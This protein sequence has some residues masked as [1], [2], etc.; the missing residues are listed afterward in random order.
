MGNETQVRTPTIV[1]VHRVLGWSG[2]LE[3][4]HRRAGSSR[5]HGPSRRRK[6]ADVAR[7]RR[8]PDTTDGG[9]GGRSG[10]ACRPF[11]RRRRHHWRRHRAQCRGPRVHRGLRAGRGRVARGD[12]P[13]RARPGRSRNVAPDSD[14]YVWIEPAARA[15]AR[16]P[17]RPTNSSSW[18][19]P[20]RRRSLRRSVTGWGTPAWRSKP[21]WYGSLERG[22][23]RRRQRAANVRPA[24]RREDHHAGR[25]PR[26]AG[27]SGPS[28]CQP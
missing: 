17:S 15:S 19:S 13:G 10:A 27:L 23:D 25:E 28:R 21:S 8:R 14:G 1:L 18:P 2:P 26:L 12:R 16:R 9:P 4:G 6:S 22:P 11:L 3:Q 7:R 20:R 24:G 5:A